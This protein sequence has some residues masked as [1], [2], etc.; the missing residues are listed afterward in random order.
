[1]AF[2]LA[3]GGNTLYKIDPATGTATALSLPSGVTLST[4]RK[5]KFAVLN[6]WVVMTNSPTVNLAID[7]EGVVR[8]LVPRAP[9]SPPFVAGGSG[10]GLT[11]TY[12]IK[13]SFVVMDT[14]GNL[15]MESAL[16]PASV[17]VAVAN[18]DL[19]IAGIAISEDSI[20]ARRL[21]RNTTL[22]TTFYNLIDVDGNVVTAAVN[23]IADASLSLLPAQPTILV[24]P[25]G[26]MQDTRLK[27]I[28]SW[29]NRLWGVSTNPDD[30][31]SVFYSEDGKVYAWPNSLTAYPKG[32]DSDGI[33]AFAPRKDQLG[34]LKK[35]GLWQI[36][37]TSNANFSIVQ[38]V[39]DKGGC[40]APDTVIVINDRAYW[41]GRDG[42]YEWSAEG[43]KNISDEMVKPWFQAKDNTYFE[44]SRFPVAFAKYNE[45]R[46]SYSLHLAA[47]GSSSEDRWVE[48][49]LTNRKWYGPHKTAAFTPSSAAV[50]LDS[51]ALPFTVV[52]GTDG[53]IY[54]ANQT[55]LHDG[56]SSVIDMDCYGPFHSVDAPD[57]EHYWGELSVLTKKDVAG[58]LSVIPY[59]GALDVAAGATIAH[60][61]TK[62]RELLRRLGDGRLCRLRFRQNTVDQGA[63]IYGYEISPVFE[64]G[65]R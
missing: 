41:L 28:T 24:P 53:V 4:T 32:Q 1:M 2:L 30:I 22:G 35:A 65:R 54:K 15:L 47:S 25:P 46:N 38:L 8:R 49:N 52:G 16:S 7:P 18:K 62:E 37:G 29:K 56:A 17:A 5:P 11:G 50:A 27:L 21:Y 31:D 10:T 14:A 51:N 60:D 34:L 9:I 55:T 45:A 12:S 40:I 26:T 6:Q 48:F 39:F 13:E 64:N 58:T 3:Q 59:V 33:V 23:S 57:I 36:T 20:T 63:I 61:L 19:S 43:V 44:T 42:V